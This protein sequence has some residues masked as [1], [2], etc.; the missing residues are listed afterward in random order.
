MSKDAKPFLDLSEDLFEQYDVITMD[1]R[2]H[3][4]SEGFFSF[5]SKEHEDIKVI[6]NYALERYR[7]VYLIGFSLGA[8]SCVIEVAQNR[9]VGGLIII[10]PPTSF[11]N[12]ENNFLDRSAVIPAIQKFGSHLFRLRLGNINSPKVN[13]LDVIDKVSPIPL[14]IIHGGNDP[15]IFRHHADMLYE[16]AKEPKKL[17]II[18]KGLHAEELYRQDSEGFVELCVSWIK[19]IC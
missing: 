1:Q 2:G 17:V 8:A 12:I 18:E 5:S 14:L 13:P 16:K 7:K 9:N 6:I 3:G 19:E 11:E 15:I 10:S 4:R